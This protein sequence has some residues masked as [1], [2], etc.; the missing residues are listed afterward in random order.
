MPLEWV[1]SLLITFQYLMIPVLV[2]KISSVPSHPFPPDVETGSSTTFVFPASCEQT[3]SS[4][5]PNETLW[6]DSIVLVRMLPTITHALW[7]EHTP[8]KQVFLR[9]SA[10]A[11]RKQPAIL[12]LKTPKKIRTPKGI[13]D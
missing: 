7:L 12:N 2:P 8:F 9:M 3:L 10:G 1:I 13:Y 6:A 11:A 5:H 4:F